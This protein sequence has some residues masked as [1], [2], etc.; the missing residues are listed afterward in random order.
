MWAFRADEC[1]VVARTLEVEAPR[2]S[3]PEGREVDPVHER[4]EDVPRLV[5]VREALLLELGDASMANLP[6]RRAPRQWR[7]EIVTAESVSSAR[8]PSE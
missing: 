5:P 1:A 7:C 3:G 4:A 8:V 6:E 2:A